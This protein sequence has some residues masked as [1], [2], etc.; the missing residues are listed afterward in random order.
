[1]KCDMD[2]C[3]KQSHIS[4]IPMRT[5][6]ILTYHHFEIQF[7][8]IVTGFMRKPCSILMEELVKLQIH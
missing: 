1:M 8:D 2:V 6:E 3:S 7:L 5:W 4:E